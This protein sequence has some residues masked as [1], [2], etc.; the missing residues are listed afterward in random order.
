M[1]RYNPGYA[2]GILTAE[3]TNWLEDLEKVYARQERQLKEIKKK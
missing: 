2:R 3:P 1:V